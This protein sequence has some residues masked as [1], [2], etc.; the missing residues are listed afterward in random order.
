MEQSDSL[1]I[2]MGEYIEKWKSSQDF[3]HI[4]LNCYQLMSSNM[5]TAAKKGEFH[6][7]NWV[8][9]LLLRFAD[10]YF[11]N[12]TS[13]DSGDQTSKVWHYTH[14]A[15][16]DNTVG[17]LQSLI[18][19]VNAHI[20]YDLVLA[21]DDLLRPEWDTLSETKQRQRYEDHCLVN[22][23]IAETIDSV[24]DNIL[25]PLNPSLAWIDSLLG[26]IDEYLISKL[27]TH[28]REEVW[29]KTQRLLKIESPN[30]R[31]SFRIKLEKEVLKRGNIISM[32]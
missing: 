31:E 7:S 13:Y 12:L 18:L 25:E 6:D 5:M 2:K 22:N 30:E 28:W 29:E 10:Y 4:F 9:L 23:V 24:Q 1:L 17:E 32:F 27:I 3:R 14:K 11:E 19:G 21:L 8:N 15:T 20:N 16:L 26:R